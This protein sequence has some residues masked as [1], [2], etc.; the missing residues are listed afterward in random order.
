VIIGVLAVT[1]KY[2]PYF[3]RTPLPIFPLQWLDFEL[4]EF[5]Q[6]LLHLSNLP[7]L[8]LVEQE[9]QLRQVRSEFASHLDQLLP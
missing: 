2:W 6:F 7:P 1:G 9:L 4:R 3:A 5:L 8:L